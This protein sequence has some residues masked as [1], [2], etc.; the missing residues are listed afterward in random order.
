MKLKNT[1]IAE[2]AGVSAETVGKV[3]TKKNG[4]KWYSEDTEK[5]VLDAFIEL[6]SAV[7][8]NA[9][10]RRYDENGI[11]MRVTI[12]T[13]GTGYENKASLMIVDTA[14]NKLLRKELINTY[15][16]PKRSSKKL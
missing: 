9:I 11:D 5:V 6:H 13:H 4:N 14:Y 16:E 3:L 2:L 12:E 10:Q 15:L 8:F 1:Q 7:L